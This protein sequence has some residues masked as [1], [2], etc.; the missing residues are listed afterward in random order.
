MV[1]VVVV[2]VVCFFFD[3]YVHLYICIH[4]SISPFS[5]HGR[6]LKQK[7]FEAT[8]QQA[9][10]VEADPVPQTVRSTASGLLGSVLID[11]FFHENRDECSGR[12]G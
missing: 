1:V 2:V 9:E 11:S 10:D 12:Q 5:A 6:F 8:L 3:T 7:Q 4:T